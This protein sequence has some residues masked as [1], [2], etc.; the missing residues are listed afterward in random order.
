MYSV[1]LKIKEISSKGLVF[2][3]FDTSLQVIDP[4]DFNDQSV[5]I[6]VLPLNET[7]R[8]VYYLELSCITTADWRMFADELGYSYV[9]I[10]RISNRTQHLERPTVL[11]LNLLTSKYPDFSLEELRDI[12]MKASDS[13][14]TLIQRIVG[15]SQFTFTV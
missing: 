5:D 7:K 14:S 3:Q 4:V 1:E 11:L 15:C 13:Y 6:W 2:I 10:K 12:C 9:N 8:L